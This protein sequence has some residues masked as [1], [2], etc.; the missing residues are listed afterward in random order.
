M[1]RTPPGRAAVLSLS[2]SP[3]ETTVRRL[4]AETG[5]ATAFQIRHGRLP[6]AG[7]EEIGPVLDALAGAGGAGDPELF[8]P[9]VRAARAAE[10]VRKALARA[11]APLL[12]QRGESLPSFVA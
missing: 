12:S 7:L 10:A 1:A 11:E 3:D 4:L 9:V 2:P 5:E 6:L 8:R